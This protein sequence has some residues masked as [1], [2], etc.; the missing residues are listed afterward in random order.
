MALHAGSVERFWAKVDKSGPGGCWLWTAWLSGGYGRFRVGPRL[1]YAHRLAYELLVGPIP[2][3]LELDHVRAR[4]CTSKACV[5]P[6]H[7]EP[8]THRENVL[9][10]DSPSALLARATHCGRGHELAGPNL[11]RGQCREC[12]R[13]TNRDLKRR[14]REA[15]R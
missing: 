15:L 8:V 6:A 3:G 11:W 7:L 2:E 12:R 14:K 13:M 5:N 4:G 10:G 1:V 9:R